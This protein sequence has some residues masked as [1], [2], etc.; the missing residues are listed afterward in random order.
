[1]NEELLSISEAAKLMGVC[2]NT[3][4][5]W[6]IEKKFIATRTDGN[7]RRY[8]LN[9]IRE[10]LDKQAAEV[11]KVAVMSSTDQL[12][13]KYAKELEDVTNPQERKQLAILID[14]MLPSH[15]KE[16]QTFSTSQIIRLT[17]ET[18]KRIRFKKM[19]SIQPLTSPCGFVYYMK[20]QNKKSMIDSSPVAVRTCVSNFSIFTKANFEDV[21]LLYAEELAAEF[22]MLIL[23]Y[24]PR[25]TCEFLSSDLSQLTKQDVNSMFDYI[26]ASDGLLKPLRSLEAFSDV[27]LC[28]VPYTKLCPKMFDL[29][30]A[31][32]KYP[33]SLLTTPTF[34]PFVLLQEGPKMGAG[35]ANLLSR[36]TFF[37]NGEESNVN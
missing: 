18:W 24:L 6:D 15:N 1:M 10:Y 14:N 21:W 11:R 20:E 13:N 29:V 30:Y 28:I 31:A 4:R 3:L 32:G 7:H 23:D 9:Q 2:E 17:K 5:D 22:D 33:T 27:D 37:K 8:S 35:I 36:Y 25:I 26:I 19:I 16:N 12:I 34:V